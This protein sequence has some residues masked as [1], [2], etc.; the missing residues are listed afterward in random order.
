MAITVSDVLK[1]Q[2][3]KNLNLIAGE[4]GLNGT[5]K[6]V[7]ILDYEFL[8]KIEGQFGEGD[9][10]ISSF[11]FAK[12]DLQL[13]INS[14]KSLIEDKVSCLAIKDVYYKELP[15][16]IIEYANEKSFP[17]FIFDNS[18]LFEDIVTDI[19]DMIRIDAKHQLVE[20]KIDSILHSDTSKDKI[21]EIAFEI[22]GDFKESFI[23]IYCKKKIDKQGQDIFWILNKY[24]NIK[25]KDE[26]AF[27]Y[28]DGVM[29]IITE[30]KIG[31]NNIEN[32]VYKFISDLAISSDEFYIGT[33]K[34]HRN[35]D[36]LNI[37]INESIYALDFG[38]ISSKSITSYNDIG[39]YKILL[40]FQDEYWMKDFYESIIHPLQNYDKKASTDMFKTAIIYVENNGNIKDTADELFQHENTIRYR[41]NKIKDILNMEENHSFYEELS[42]AVKIYKILSN[43]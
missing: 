24:N 10:I 37:G 23:T 43:K 15:S 39:I 17:I 20:E 32:L 9:F 14:I 13:F 1:I 30:D 26:T 42:I 38:K 25:N 7:G 16:E 12:D 18:I 22:N 31:K 4:D 3:L 36:E 19:T 33:S 5:V 6:K 34:I 41:I 40:P 11:L 2:G 27:K 21:R 8:D 29:G 35:I 28:K